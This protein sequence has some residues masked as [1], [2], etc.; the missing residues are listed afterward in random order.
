MSRIRRFGLSS[1]RSRFLYA[2]LRLDFS[3]FFTDLILTSCKDLPWVTKAQAVKKPHSS[4]QAI[5][6]QPESSVAL[7]GYAL[8]IAEISPALSA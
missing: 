2:C 6:S 4:S 7:R 5:R 8:T 1:R 3:F